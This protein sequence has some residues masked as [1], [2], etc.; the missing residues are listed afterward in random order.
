FLIKWKGWSS[1]YNSW[2]REA[3]VTNCMSLVVRCCLEKSIHSSYRHDLMR[4]ALRL[5]CDSEK[6]DIMVLSQLVGHKVPVN[7]YISRKEVIDI[8][9]EGLKLLELSSK[10][11]HRRLAEVF[12]SWE[13]FVKRVEARR[14]QAEVIKKWEEEINKASGESCPLY[15]EN[16]VDLAE[17]P[18]DFVYIRDFKPGPGIQFPEDPMVGCNCSDCFDCRK[19]CCPVQA[20]AAFVYNKHGTLVANRGSAIFECN[21]R[22]KCSQDCPNRV[23]QKGRQ[24]P[25]TIFRTPN[26]RGWGVRTERRIKKGTFLF[27]YLGEVIT[28]EEAERRGQVYDE[29]GIT[30]LFDLD[31]DKKEEAIYT[32]DAG[33]YGNVSH[34]VNHSCE[35]NMTVYSVW[36]NNLDHRMPRLAFFANRDIC[37]QEELTFDYKMSCE[38]HWF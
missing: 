18:E 22:C 5:V 9:R 21:R 24:V 7:G 30:Y 3:S 28:D 34:F 37:C 36:I 26:D 20:N 38:W 32:V 4:W 27:E 2:E 35:S 12:G 6:P 17:P 31:Y 13:E 23:V 25:L 19:E 14:E 33:F 11:L 29:Q 1:E 8:R 15:V 10:R 16:H